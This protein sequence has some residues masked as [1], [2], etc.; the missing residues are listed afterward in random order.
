VNIFI[1]NHKEVIRLLHGFP[2]IDFVDI[3][4]TSDNGQTWLP[5][6]NN[7]HSTGAFLWTIPF[8]Q[9]ST[10]AR[11][12]IFD[13]SN[14]DT[15]DMS[16]SHFYL[17]IAPGINVEKPAGGN[18]II[19][20]NGSAKLNWDLLPGETSYML[21]YSVN[22]GKV[23]RRLDYKNISTRNKGS[24]EFQNPA[25][26]GESYLVRIRSGEKYSDE[27]NVLVK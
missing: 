10:L 22:S 12:R 5:I 6:V 16:D 2:G 19:G 8:G 26:S 3:E 13:A 9:P 18:I 4:Y 14:H 23:W 25:N 21:E 20:K 15:T 1:E 24:L 7:Y 27:I 11:I 17:H